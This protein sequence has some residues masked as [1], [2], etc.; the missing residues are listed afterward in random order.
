MV[1]LK[2]LSVNARPLDINCVTLMHIDSNTEFNKAVSI[3]ILC[4]KLHL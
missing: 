2:K 3:L 1:N 4:N